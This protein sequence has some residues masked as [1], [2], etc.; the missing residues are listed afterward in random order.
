MCWFYNCNGSGDGSKDD[1][2]IKGIQAAPSGKLEVTWWLPDR[3]TDIC[4]HSHRPASACTCHDDAAASSRYCLLSTGSR[5]Q[6]RDHVCSVGVLFL[7]ISFF[8][9]TPPPPSITPAPQQQYHSLATNTHT[10]TR[11][12]HRTSTTARSFSNS[13]DSSRSALRR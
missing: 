8:L 1:D 6:V 10:Y 7:L 11:P 5:T 13:S 3:G 2:D 4:L 12:S 9:T